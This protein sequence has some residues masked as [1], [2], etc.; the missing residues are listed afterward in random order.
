LRSKIQKNK[1]VFSEKEE[2]KYDF[3]FDKKLSEKQEKIFKKINISK[4]KKFLLH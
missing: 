3:D 2:L 1:I 4:D